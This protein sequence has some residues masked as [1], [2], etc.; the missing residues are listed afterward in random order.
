MIKSEHGANT[1]GTTRKKHKTTKRRQARHLFNNYNVLYND[2]AFIINRPKRRF[3][4][5]PKKII[6]T[7]VLTANYSRQNDCEIIITGIIIHAPCR[8]SKKE[9]NNQIRNT[10][11][12]F[13]FLY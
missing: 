13:L 8:N 1:V 12:F 11:D 5:I 9:K 7:K 6:K 10:K 3:F 2:N 4:V